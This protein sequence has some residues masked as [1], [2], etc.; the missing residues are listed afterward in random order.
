MDR[1]RNK[2]LETL[3]SMSGPF[4]SAAAVDQYISS[5]IDDD[6]KL[7]RLY[8]EV[9]YARDTLLSLPKTSDLFRLI[10]YHKK[11]PLY[12]YAVNIK[13]HLN[14]VTSNADVTSDDLTKVMDALLKPT[15]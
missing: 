4:T 3:K 13:L 5:D 9:R 8:L 10:I 1:R 6:T 12:T 15:K 7:K 14:N 2:D 11:L